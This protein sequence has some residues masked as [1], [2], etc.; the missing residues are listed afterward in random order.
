MLMHHICGTAAK[1][2]NIQINGKFCNL[3]TEIKTGENWFSSCILEQSSIVYVC[4]M[5]VIT[6]SDS[7]LRFFFFFF[8][9][10]KVIEIR[11]KLAHVD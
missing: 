11:I 7:E 1:D 10:G 3:G 2:I 6:V 4:T 8:M 5:A 9:R